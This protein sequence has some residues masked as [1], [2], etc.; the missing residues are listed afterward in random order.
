MNALSML[1]SLPNS[2]TS[3]MKT[4]GKTEGHSAEADR[5]TLQRKAVEFE[6]VYLTQMLQPMFESLGDAAEPF[7]NGL[8]QDVWR[9]MQV[10]QYGKALAARGGIGLADR[11]GR[12]LIAAQEAH[13]GGRR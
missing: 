9:S 13:S 7:G 2:A 4:A 3:P 10:E 11:I 8:G 12:E 6:S 5:K 1:S